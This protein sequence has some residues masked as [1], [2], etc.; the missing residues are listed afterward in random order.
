MKGKGHAKAE[1]FAG[2]GTSIKRM[3]ILLEVT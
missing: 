1:G 3:V 2:R